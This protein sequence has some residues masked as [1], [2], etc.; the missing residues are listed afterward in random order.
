MQLLAGARE[1]GQE[2]R[3]IVAVEALALAPALASH[4]REALDDLAEAARVRVAQDAAAERREA[5]AEDRGEVER[6]RPVDDGLRET[7]RRLVGHR[8]NAAIDDVVRAHLARRA[9]PE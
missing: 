7:A 1:L 8:Q 9:A 5:G 4:L 3:R 2:R 6:A